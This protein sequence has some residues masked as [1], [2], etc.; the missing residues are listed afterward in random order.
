MPRKWK[1]LHTSWLKSTSTDLCRGL[2][3]TRNDS[4]QEV[5][6][7]GQ[8]KIWVHRYLVNNAGASFGLLPAHTYNEEAWIKTVDI[9]LHGTVPGFQGLFSLMTANRRHVNI[10]SKAGKTPPGQRAYAVASRSNYANKSWPGVVKQ[11]FASMRSARD[12]H[13]RPSV[14][15]SRWRQNF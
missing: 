15:D 1:R 14:F 12:H 8:G 7:E 10:A 5:V 3:V 2:D 4:I 13:D 9:N 11:G 6:S